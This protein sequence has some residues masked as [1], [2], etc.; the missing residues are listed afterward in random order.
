MVQNRSCHWSENSNPPL[1][2]ILSTELRALGLK[3]QTFHQCSILQSQQQYSL[4]RKVHLIS[5]C[6]LSLGIPFFVV[7]LCFISII[8]PWTANPNLWFLSSVSILFS[9]RIVHIGM[10]TVSIIAYIF[11]VFL[12][13]QWRKWQKRSHIIKFSQNLMHFNFKLKEVPNCWPKNCK[14]KKKS[15]SL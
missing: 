6:I 5:L 12:V 2:G 4:S 10:A 3:N 13:P 8:F 14:K 9:H 1:Q 11:T 15:V 7:S